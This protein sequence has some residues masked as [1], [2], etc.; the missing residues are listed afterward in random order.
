MRTE[1]AYS[2]IV[3]TSARMLLI[4]V[5]NRKLRIGPKRVS[6]IFLETM[7]MRGVMRR[8][9]VK[10]SPRAI[11]KL[12]RARSLMNPSSPIITCSLKEKQ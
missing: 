10:L 8:S 4:R 12:K 2:G 11:E 9:I 5:G 3:S 6:I 7:K 1:S